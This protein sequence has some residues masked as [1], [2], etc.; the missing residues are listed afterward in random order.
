[1]GLL[2]ATL[3]VTVIAFAN[4]HIS[5]ADFMAK[6]AQESGVTKLASGLMYKVLETGPASG[7]MPAINTPCQVTYAGQL[8]NGK[9]FDAGTTS[10]APNQ[11]IRGWTE[12]MQLMH[13]GDKWEMY[14]PSDLAYGAR[15]AGGVIPG[16]AALV[17]QMELI[18]IK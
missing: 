5:D 16:N 18:K 1:M 4:A 10:F 7:P 17:F 15:G 12:A 9:Q 2:K 6:K 11:V 3:T 8:V 14:I 13:E